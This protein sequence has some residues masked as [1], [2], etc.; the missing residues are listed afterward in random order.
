MTNK[1]LSRIKRYLQLTE[2][3]LRNIICDRDE[4]IEQL[5]EI[6][7][8]A[9][10]SNYE[11]E[12]AEVIAENKRLQERIKLLEGET[13]RMFGELFQIAAERNALDKPCKA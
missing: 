2:D 11:S 10:E 12:V 8:D 7:Q 5:S 9:R 6:L 3:E 4:E 1:H 13:S